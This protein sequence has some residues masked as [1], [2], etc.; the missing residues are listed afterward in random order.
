MN[1]LGKVV[2]WVEKST[3]IVRKDVFSQYSSGVEIRRYVERLIEY[4]GN[5]DVDY[6]KRG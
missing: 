5:S 6:I 1:E 4:Y 3:W 2:G